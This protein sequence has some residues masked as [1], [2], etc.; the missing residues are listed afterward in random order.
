MCVH[1]VNV[2]WKTARESIKELETDKEFPEVVICVRELQLIVIAKVTRALQRFPIK[3][4]ATTNV[5]VHKIV[6]I[7]DSMPPD[8]LETCLLINLF[9]INSFAFYSFISHCAAFTFVDLN[10]VTEINFNVSCTHEET[11][12][13]PGSRHSF[14]NFLLIFL[15]ILFSGFFFYRSFCLLLCSSFLLVFVLLCIAFRTKCF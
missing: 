1:K 7:T 10:C 2:N 14:E 8:V 15:L 6:Q 9:L 5:A 4:L 13:R 3:A 11:F 12:S